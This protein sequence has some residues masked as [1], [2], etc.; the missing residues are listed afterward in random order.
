MKAR[1]G[2]E[3]SILDEGL[4]VLLGRRGRAE[5]RAVRAGELDTII[6]AAIERSRKAE[7]TDADTTVYGGPLLESFR[8]IAGLFPGLYR[9][10]FGSTRFPPSEGNAGTAFLM[11]RG[12]EIGMWLAALSAGSSA[13]PRMFMSGTSGKAADFGP[14]RELY[15]ASEIDAS[16]TT[17]FRLGPWMVLLSGDL[18]YE[19]LATTALEVTW[20]F[21]EEFTAPPHVIA[22]RPSATYGTYTGVSVDDFVDITIHPTVSD[23]ALRA[24]KSAT[25]TDFAAGDTITKGSAIAI[26]RWR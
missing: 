26:G 18:T 2:T 14:W 17:G 19:Y 9:W 22:M 12:D 3:G 6:A 25:A 5:D 7:E 16:G 23:V 13:E 21:P 8:R 15:G 24:R 1:K 11:K 4:G 10:R 20:T